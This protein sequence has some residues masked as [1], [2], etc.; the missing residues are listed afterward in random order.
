[1]KYVLFCVVQLL[2]T[3]S[4]P[5]ESKGKSTLVQAIFR[6]LEAEEGKITI[7]GVD[8]ATMGLHKLRKFIS[9]IN[10]VPVLF[11]GSVKENLDPFEK[12]DT[13]SIRN[14]LV[15]VQMID[16]IDK[17]PLGINSQVTEGGKNFS[18]GERVSRQFRIF[19]NCWLLITNRLLTI[20]TATALSGEGDTP[21]EQD[22]CT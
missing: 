2:F 5:F 16:T 6:I 11:S 15:S 8:I 20:T 13:A 14:A 9:V 19:T 4:H 22:T 7:D 1:L 3:H 17:L 21:K 12:F 18:V 10:Q